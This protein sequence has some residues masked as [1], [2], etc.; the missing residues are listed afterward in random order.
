M[1]WRTMDVHE[2]RV[3]FVAAATRRSQS[4]GSL[5][6]EFGISR[7][8]GYLWLRRYQQQGEKQIPRPSHP[9]K[10]KTGVC[11]GP[12]IGPRDDNVLTLTK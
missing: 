3:E 4:F 8:T 9:N 5:C 7:P 12:G 2:Q 10:R 1:P 11:W 6:D